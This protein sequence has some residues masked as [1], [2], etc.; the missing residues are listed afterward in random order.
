MVVKKKKLTVHENC[1]WHHSA[2][3]NLHGLESLLAQTIR[4]ALAKRYW[5][6]FTVSNDGCYRSEVSSTDAEL[7]AKVPLSPYPFVKSLGAGPGCS[8]GSAG[9]ACPRE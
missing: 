8:E 3:R 9:G 2:A 1:D 5:R 7:L 4:A 6:G